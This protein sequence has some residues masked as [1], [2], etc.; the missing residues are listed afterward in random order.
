MIKNILKIVTVI[1]LF[2]G[3]NF[4][5]QSIGINTTNPDPS[6]SLDVTST[7]KGVLFPQYDLLTLNSVSSPVANPADGLIIYNKGGASIHPKGYYVWIKN[8]WQRFIVAGSEPQ[9]MSLIINSPSEQTPLIPVNSTNNVAKPLSVI[10][11]KITGASLAS[12]TETITLPAGKYIIRYG[13]DAVDNSSN[14][15]GPAN[16]TYLGH[17]LTATRSYLVN[18]TTNAVLTEQNREVQLSST[19]RFFQGTFYLTLTSPTPIKT[20][21]EFDTGNGFTRSNLLIRTSYSMVITKMI[22]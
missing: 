3:E 4:F 16:T 9:S 5:S 8:Q 2:S 20:K 7:N 1:F 12:D 13:V 17:V 10:S 14:S 22:D 15:T 18:A 21:F 6:S 19:F 11:N